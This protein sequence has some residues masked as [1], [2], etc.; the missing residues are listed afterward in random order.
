MNTNDLITWRGVMA[1]VANEGEFLTPDEVA[2]QLKCSVAAVQ[3]WARSGELRGCRAG[4]LWRFK[5]EDVN[6][7]LNRDTVKAT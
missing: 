2:S 1:K 4:N 5:P 7:F 3:K 6:A